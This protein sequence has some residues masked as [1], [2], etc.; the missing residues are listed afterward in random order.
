MQTI[1]QT[2]NSIY[3]NDQVRSNLDKLR[4]G[5]IELLSKGVTNTKTAK[6]E[7]ETYI[8][9]LSPYKG[10]SKG[11]NLCPNAQNCIND[12][13][14]IQ[15]RGRFSSVQ[16]SR[17]AKTEFYLG[18]RVEF[19]TQLVKE[20]TKIYTK[21]QNTK[22]KICV[23]LNGTSDLDFLAIV[24]NRLNFDLLDYST[25]LESQNFG[26]IFYD[27]TKILGKVEKYQNTNYSLTYSFQGTNLEESLKAL[28]LNANLAVVFRKKLPLEFLNTMV[29]DGDKSDLQT[30]NHKGKVLGLKAKGSAKKDKSGFVVD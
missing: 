10:N 20:L 24:K 6:N 18:H 13:L 12:C 25:T 4:K 28:E 11:I 22:T 15:G 21:A 29:V 1:P 16:N 27:Y 26:I 7:L 3:L 14:F 5:K 17:I 23:R 30:I 8:L 2:P 19:L 9:Y